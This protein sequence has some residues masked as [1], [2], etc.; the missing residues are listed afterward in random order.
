[1]IQRFLRIIAVGALKNSENG[2]PYMVIKFEPKYMLADGTPIGSAILEGT[3]TVFGPH[4]DDKGNEF[5]GD[6]LFKSISEGQFK[7]GNLVEGQ[8]CRVTTTPY[9]IPGT[10]REVSSYTCALFAHENLREYVNKQLKDSYACMIDGD[11]VT[12][13]DQLNK[14]V[15][16][17]ERVGESADKL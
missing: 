14:P 16:A 7:V 12:A 3:R 1:M 5:K 6:G 13:P 9:N 10:D 4:K 11:Y 17:S 15:I 2:N 8:L